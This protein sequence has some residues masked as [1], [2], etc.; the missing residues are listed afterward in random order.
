MQ[1]T[2]S[3][4]VVDDD[5]AVRNAVT[6]LLEMAGHQVEAVADIPQAIEALRTSVPDV[7]VCDYMLGSDTVSGL[8]TASEFGNVPTRV[9]L[10]GHDAS[11]IGQSL[12]SRFTA[13]VFKTD[14]AD[15]LLSA[16]GADS[17]I[18]FNV[19][20]PATRLPLPQYAENLVITRLPVSVRK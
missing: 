20:F 3:T 11:E 10:T 14:A 2:L 5:E 4:L 1:R 12:I 15:S 6:A 13:V 19:Q 7:I 18:L 16:V 9:L 8:T 17:P